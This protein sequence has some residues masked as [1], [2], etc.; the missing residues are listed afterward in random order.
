MEQL[1]T[2]ALRQSQQAEVYQA[3]GASTLVHFEANRVKQVEHRQ[4]ESTALRL[5]R[6]GRTGFA[7]ASGDTPPA[8]L[9][10]MAVQ[11]SAFG[12]TAGGAC[13]R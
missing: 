9:L 3:R 13:R 10:D 8:R 12:A 7:A 5:V 1:V 4:S 6:D 2:L 11:T